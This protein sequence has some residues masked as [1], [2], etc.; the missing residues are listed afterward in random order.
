VEK[1]KQ[2]TKKL[3]NKTLNWTEDTNITVFEGQDLTT[4][5]G[6]N[7]VYTV[8]PES[9]HSASLFPFNKQYP[10]MTT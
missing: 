7:S 6:N 4:N 3:E 1:E 8:H 9:I 2:I 5:T 10:I